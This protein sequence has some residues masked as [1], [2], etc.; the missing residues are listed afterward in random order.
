M[1]RPS[2]TAISRGI[3]LSFALLALACAAAEAPDPAPGLQREADALRQRGQ[4]EE[5][6]ELYNQAVE[7]DPEL[8]PAYLGLA[9]AYSSIGDDAEA[10]RFYL[11]A[12]A[13]DPG[14]VQTKLNLAGFYYRSRNYDRALAVLQE[15]M[16]IAPEGDEATLISGLWTRVES[17]QVRAR[18]RQ[19]LLEGLQQ[20]PDDAE[21]ATQLA[22][23]YARE[24]NDLLQS[25]NAEES[26]E[27]VLE[28]MNVVP[29][30]HQAELYYIGAQTRS[31]H[32][33]QAGALE[34]LDR[35][36]ELDDAVPGFHLSRAGFLIEAREFE[37]ALV[38]LDRVIELAP[39]SEEAEFARLRREDVERFQQIPEDRLEEYMN[40]RRGTPPLAKKKGSGGS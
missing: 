13:K 8:A 21:I 12:A 38:E 34:W 26:H 15:A 25:G 14:D 19:N 24:A 1:A 5:A 36:I 33:D 18:V 3:V 20:D 39:N 37:E 6:I 35:A 30:Q 17:A 9:I 32:D 11:V 23:S 4:Y 10:E 31:A 7:A 40:E 2:Q 16:D 29:E 27:V 28:G 22:D